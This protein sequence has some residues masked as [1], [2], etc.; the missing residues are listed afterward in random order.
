M[1]PKHL[2]FGMTYHRIYMYLGTDA[3]FT[4]EKQIPI[5]QI[6]HNA[7]ILSE[8]GVRLSLA[9]PLRTS[10]TSAPL[11]NIPR[12]RYSHT[13]SNSS[14]PQYPP[15]RLHTPPTT[16]PNLRSAHKPTQQ[17]HTPSNL[18]RSNHYTPRHPRNPGRSQL[19]QLSTGPHP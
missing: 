18:Q 6:L 15:L 3:G 8:P 9:L 10:T 12:S 1:T 14:P 11:N 19:G 2:G 5:V 17:D 7:P 4:I 13:R 16:F